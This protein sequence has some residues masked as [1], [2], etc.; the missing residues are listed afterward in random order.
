MRK[1]L[2]LTAILL[3]A[4][5]TSFKNNITTEEVTPEPEAALEQE[6]KNAALLHK[7]KNDTEEAP[8]LTIHGNR[9]ESLITFT[10]RKGNLISHEG[11]FYNVNFQIMLHEEAPE[12]LTKSQIALSVPIKSMKTD[13]EGLTTHLLSPDFFDS[14]TYPQATFLST[15]IERVEGTMYGIEGNLTLHG[16]SKPVSFTAEITDTGLAMSY[17]LDRNTFG[18][19]KPGGIDAEI[20]LEITIPFVRKH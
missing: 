18:I 2:L 10:G 8:S 5:S 20:P 17:T 19:G 16:V 12:D 7:E 1:I 6:T 4:C 13:N 11:A 14:D 9:N 15:N 3:S